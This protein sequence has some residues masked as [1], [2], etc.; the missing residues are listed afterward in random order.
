MR[1]NKAL[2]LVGIV[3][4]A[5]L[6]GLVGHFAGLSSG[7]A[8]DNGVAIDGEVPI[9]APNGPT[10]VLTGPMDVVF[11]GIPDGSDTVDIV[12]SAGNVT[13]NGTDGAAV[14]FPD[15]ATIEG[16]WTNTSSL[17]VIGKPI[18]ID[19]GDKPPVTVSGDITQLDVHQ[20]M[21]PDDA[22][23]DFV[24]SSSLGSGSITLN[25]LPANTQIAAVDPDSNQVMDVQTTD[26]SG[27]VTYTGLDSGTHTVELMTSQ[28]GPTVDNASASP[29][30]SEVTRFED[31]TLSIDVSDPD[32]PDDGVTVEFFVD[33]SSV[34]TDTLTTN[35][36][37]SVNVGPLADGSHSWHVEA[38]D[39]YGQNTTSS[40]FTW[41]IDHFDPAIGNM[42]PAD[43]AGLSQKEA[44]LS[45]DVSDGDFPL[46]G[47]SVDV[48]IYFDGSVVH[49]ETITS[50]STVSTTVQDVTGGSHTWHVEATD[51][52]HGGSPV[53]S[54]TNTLEVPDELR[55]FNESDPTTLVDNATVTL[56]FYVNNGS[57]TDVYTRS[58]TTGKINMTGLPVDKSFVAVAKADGYVNRR[59]YVASL[60]DTQR[61]YLSP[62]TANTLE[63]TFILTD[64]S[65]DYP[66]ENS[67]LQIQ[68]SLNGSWQ[69]VEGDYF[70]ATSKF[71]AHL[72]Y[73]ERHRLIIVNTETGD[74]KRL[75]TFIPVV[76]GEY[77]ITIYQSGETEVGG[78]SP[79][80]TT[81]PSVRSLY[82]NQSTNIS[83]T[84]NPQSATLASYTVTGVYEA[85]NGT[86][87]TLF[88]DSGSNGEGETLTNAVD[89]TGLDGGTVYINTTWETSTG[90]TGSDSA[91][92]TVLASY[93][94]QYSLL[95]VAG[96]LTGR[97]AGGAGGAFISLLA[98][99][100]TAL[101]TAAIAGTLRLSTMAS[102][103]V[104]TGFIA[105]FVIIGWLGVQYL[106]V[107]GV[108]VVVVGGI[109]SG[110]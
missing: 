16:T 4:G 96:D 3:L 101:G 6:L 1:R 39:E 34:G 12:S 27:Q 38:T 10:V 81:K 49:S 44:M 23:P 105:L 33:G 99:L 13:V 89:L 9:T 69:T 45:A 87:T 74:S 22:T 37:A 56:E 83:V 14:T 94:N 65:G 43:G 72:E 46:D 17:D 25:S 90:K 55:I 106:F 30:G 18:T 50:N 62:E 19:P 57:S 71:A 31:Q 75:G 86:K 11:P 73:N 98:L 76:A 95:A 32:F 68:R 52:Y 28:G 61:I 84:I 107:A 51:D 24:Y 109:R 104:A 66:A 2:L 15:P 92:Y 58:T 67:V 110:V 103:L 26:G 54:S 20:G 35:G 108:A 21:A 5:V 29:S 102:G 41:E 70:G 8:L 7:A 91:V 85:S 42:D 63:I 60:F 77:Q 48:E 40:T 97:V 59:I 79:I 53:T 93:D 64:Y 36:T 80:V 100:L 47:D 78:L 88:T 82:G